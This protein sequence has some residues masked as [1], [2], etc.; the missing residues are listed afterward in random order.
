MPALHEKELEGQ[1]ALVTGASRGIGYAIACELADMGAYVVGTATTPQGAE[2]FTRAFTGETQDG[3]GVELDL[4]NRD[5]FDER[6]EKIV[7][8]AGKPISILVNNAGI[9][10][11]GLFMRMEPEQ[12]D[13]VVGVNLSGTVELTRKVVRNMRKLDSGRVI[14]ISSLAGIMGNPGQANYVATKA[15][16]IAVNK[17]WVKELS[18]MKFNHVTFNVVAPGYIET[19]MTDALPEEVIDTMVAHTPTGRP[20]QPE[21]VAQLVGFLASPRASFINGEVIR[22]DG[23]MGV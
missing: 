9:T 10:E 14:T 3:S 5:T 17:T 13:R 21:D 22:V 11:D 6:L 12:W 20:G 8:A 7:E 1:V 16:L 15:A 2:S 18:P 23:G 19:D 4:G